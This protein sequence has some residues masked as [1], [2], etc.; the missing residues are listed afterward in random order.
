MNMCKIYKQIL[1][2]S[3][4]HHFLISFFGI[5]QRDIFLITKSVNRFRQKL[6]S[7]EWESV[8]MAFGDEYSIQDKIY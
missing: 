1:S 3:G 7:C 2:K 6:M 4:I 8:N 5:F